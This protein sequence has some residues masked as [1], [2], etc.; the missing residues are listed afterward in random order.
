[1]VLIFQPFPKL[2]T[3]RT[4]D[5]RSS[6]PTRMDASRKCGP[7]AKLASC[8]SFVLAIWPSQFRL[9]FPGTSIQRIPGSVHEIQSVNFKNRMK[10]Q[11]GGSRSQLHQKKKPL[12]PI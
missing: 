8:S 11:Q 1:M 7:S 4:K 10:L 6:I 5:L 3:K 12:V 2:L 9:K